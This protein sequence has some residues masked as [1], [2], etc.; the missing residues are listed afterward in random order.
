MTATASA[1]LARTV[2][3]LRMGEASWDGLLLATEVAA[4]ETGRIYRL[5]PVETL[6]LSAMDEPASTE[7][8]QERVESSC[9]LRLP[10]ATVN[11]LV[12]TFIRHGLIQEETGAPCDPVE[13]LIPAGPAEGGRRRGRRF[14][15]PGAL[16]RSAG[17]VW[18]LSG[19]PLLTA[20]CVAGIAL[21]AVTI[22]LSAVAWQRV[23]GNARTIADLPLLH[24]AG[25][26]LAVVVWHMCSQLG[27]ELSHAAAF[28][29]LGGG[30]T[31]ILT[32]TKLGPIPVPSTRL[33][34]MRLVIGRWRR[35]LVALAGP[36]FT[37]AFALIPAVASTRTT[38]VD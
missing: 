31:P 35:F 10:A 8:I 5:G 37:L 28:A 27:H 36:L 6:V 1:A 9:G 3:G 22:G 7:S 23:T 26:V 17:A 25:V 18:R 24:L 2:P 19:T 15:G 20:G 34:G 14:T 13:V 29:R 38:G 30:R 33:E 16:P 11:R 12:D 4:G 32:V 21:A